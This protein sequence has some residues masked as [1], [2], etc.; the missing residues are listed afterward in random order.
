MKNALG[1]V[2]SLL[3]WAGARPV[4]LFAFFCMVMAAIYTADNLW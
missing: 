3:I 1:A 2:L 4:T